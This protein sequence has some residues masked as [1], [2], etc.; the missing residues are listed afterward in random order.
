[1]RRRWSWFEL[2]EEKEEVQVDRGVVAEVE[3]KQ[4]LFWGK[5]LDIF[6]K[7]LKIFCHINLLV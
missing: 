6:K 3:E 4:L 5:K 7:S 2:V 1:V